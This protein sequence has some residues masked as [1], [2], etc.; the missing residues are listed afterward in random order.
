MTTE[1]TIQD[2]AMIARNGIDRVIEPVAPIFESGLT[3]SWPN[4]RS[5]VADL[6]D[7]DRIAADDGADAYY[8]R[9]RRGPWLS[10]LIGVLGVVLIAAWCAIN[11]GC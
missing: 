2:V 4:W 6:S 9:P 8:N 10:A 3:R 11:G 7:R 5:P 1:Q